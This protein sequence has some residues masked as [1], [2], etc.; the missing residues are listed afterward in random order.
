[1]FQ[2]DSLE[3]RGMTLILSVHYGAHTANAF[4]NGEQMLF[5]EGDGE[6]FL[7][8]TKSLEVVAHELTHGVI[9]YESNLISENEPGALNEHFADVMSVVAEQWHKRQTVDQADWWIGGELLGPTVNARG[10]RTFTEEKAYVDNPYLGTDPQPKHVRDKYV[11]TDDYGGVHID[12]G[13]PNHAFYFY[14]IDLDCSVSA[15]CGT[16]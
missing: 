13:I 12:C 7:R 14:C 6:L 4:W 11:G 15:Y 5:G 2:R 3:G 1:L 10:I 8:F 16:S 9:Q